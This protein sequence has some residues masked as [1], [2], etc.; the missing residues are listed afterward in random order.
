MRVEWSRGAA[1]EA[2]ARELLEL[3][4]S[5]AWTR[6][7]LALALARSNRAPE[8]LHEAEEAVRIGVD[9][10][11]SKLVGG[12]IEAVQLPQRGQWIRQGQKVWSVIRNG[13]KI[14]MVSPIEGSVADWFL[15]NKKAT[16]HSLLAAIGAASYTDFLVFARS[17]EGLEGGADGSHGVHNPFLAR[18]LLGADITELQAKYPGLPPPSPAVKSLMEGPLGVMLSRVYHPTSGPGTLR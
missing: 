7:E 8:A 1:T 18:A 12:K 10:F 6:R 3:A 4:P 11:A 14:E 2:A 17:A 16:V 5:D 9:D 15:V 13:Q